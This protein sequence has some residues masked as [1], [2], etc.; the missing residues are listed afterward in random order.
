M[1]RDEQLLDSD[2]YHLGTQHSSYRSSHSDL[3]TSQCS[4]DDGLGTDEEA[5]AQYQELW[6]VQRSA[7]SGESSLHTILW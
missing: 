1:P 4:N 7:T 3:G 5:D 2:I 6:G